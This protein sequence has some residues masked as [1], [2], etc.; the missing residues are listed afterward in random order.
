M[1]GYN[2]QVKRD[3]AVRR[4]REHLERLQATYSFKSM[5][6][7]GSVARDGA[8]PD[9]DVDILVD[10]T[11]PPRFRQ[12]MGLKFELEDLLGQRVDLV[13]RAALRPQWR[14]AIEEDA[15]LVA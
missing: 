8:G 4:I 15:L 1:S 6:V 3:E 7:F 13:D 9:S 14:D 12:F 2:G 10:F 11:E 5:S